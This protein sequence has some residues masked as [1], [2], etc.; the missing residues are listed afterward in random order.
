MVNT[1]TMSLE[2]YDELKRLADIAK[3]KAFKFRLNES[4][5]KIEIVADQLFLRRAMEEF[6]AE[7]PDYNYAEDPIYFS[8]YSEP[9]VSE[10]G[11]C[12]ELV[13]PVKEETKDDTDF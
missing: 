2:K 1:V 12:I 3:E 6:I 10:Y 7:N 13:K 11:A 9:S 5:H 4:S 8:T